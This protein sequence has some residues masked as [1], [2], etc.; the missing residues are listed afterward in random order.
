M[1]KRNSGILAA[2]KGMLVCLA[3]L[4]AVSAAGAAGPLSAS[5]EPR[6]SLAQYQPL[7]LRG[8]GFE[9]N[10]L[11]RVSARLN[12]RA[13]VK[14]GFRAGALGGFMA[15]LKTIRLGRCGNELSVTAVGGRGSRV[16]WTL[17]QRDC[18]D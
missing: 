8:Q 1:T 15:P 6:V 5:N 14:A 11:V 17:T 18:Q 7:T 12:A 9:A 16:A 4:V 3:A 2:M 10:E 13:P